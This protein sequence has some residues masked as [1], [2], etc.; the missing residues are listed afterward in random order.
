MGSGGKKPP[1]QSDPLPFAVNLVNPDLKPGEVP[2]SERVDKEKTLELRKKFADRGTLPKMAQRVHEQLTGG[3]AIHIPDEDE[4]RV[5]GE[6]ARSDRH[7]SICGEC[8]LFDYEAGQQF[9]SEHGGAHAIIE[10]LGGQREASWLG[11]WRKYGWCEAQ[12]CPADFHGPKCEHFEEKKKSRFGR[13]LA[14]TW[15]RFRDI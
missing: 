3:G 13:I 1:R 15:K 6:E 2:D 12:S 9:L 7:W 14:G 11:D 10:A 5:F 8:A 4:T